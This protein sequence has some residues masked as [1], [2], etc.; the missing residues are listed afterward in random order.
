MNKPTDREV[1]LCAIKRYG[2]NVKLVQFAVVAGFVTLW[3]VLAQTGVIDD[4]IF[5]SPSR[6]WDV[7][8]TM[9]QADLA[10]HILITVLE[11]VA[12]FAAGVVLGVM[13]IW[14][15]SLVV[16]V[17]MLGITSN[18]NGLF[19]LCIAFLIMILMSITSIVSKQAEKIK[20]LT[21]TIAKMEKRIRELEDK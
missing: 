14:P 12:G 16:F 1:Y 8:V 10:K 6:I 13:V 9:A 4:F 2:R 19:I 18:M 3:E 20:N 17:H 7:F 5:S 11:T 21:Q 15:Q